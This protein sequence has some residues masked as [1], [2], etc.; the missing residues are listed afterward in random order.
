MGTGELRMIHWH[1][2]LMFL[3]VDR[4]I[5]VS[6]PRSVAR[7]SFSTSSSGA[8]PSSGIWNGSSAST[9]RASTAST[10]GRSSVRT[11]GAKCRGCSLAPRRWQHGRHFDA[12]LREEYHWYP[13]GLRSVQRLNGT[14]DSLNTELQRTLEARLNG[15]R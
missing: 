14:I 1:V 8:L 4:S 2:S 13:Q 3:P 5:T 11:N 7:R 15:R 12:R 10:S 6:A 9:L